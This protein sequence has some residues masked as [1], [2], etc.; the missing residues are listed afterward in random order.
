MISLQDLTVGQVS[1]MIAAA[2]FVG[3]NLVLKLLGF[4]NDSSSSI[5]SSN[6]STGHPARLA[7]TTVGCCHRDCCVL[8]WHIDSNEVHKALTSE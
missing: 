1:G 2:V 8:V 7:S 4:I 5:P 3:M 6:S